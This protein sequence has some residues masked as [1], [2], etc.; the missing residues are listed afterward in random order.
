MPS[1]TTIREKTAGEEFEKSLT[2]LIHTDRYA[3][4][5]CYNLHWLQGSSRAET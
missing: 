1:S 4:H 5:L 3:S 2:T